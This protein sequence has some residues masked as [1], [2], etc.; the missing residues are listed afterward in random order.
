MGSFHPKVS[1]LNMRRSHLLR[2][3]K[4]GK[5]YVEWKRKQSL[6]KVGWSLL[7]KVV[8]G[9]PCVGEKPVKFGY[10]DY[11]VL[12]SARVLD[13]VQQSQATQGWAGEWLSSSRAGVLSGGQ[14]RRR[15]NT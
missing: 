14:D 4:S 7:E 3:R 15:K 1:L 13:A 2:L 5:S 12:P 6:R 9:L 11:T 8:L 10:G